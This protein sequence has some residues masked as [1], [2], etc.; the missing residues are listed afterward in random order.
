M[1]NMLMDT[2]ILHQEGFASRQMKLLTRLTEGERVNVYIPEIVK[3]ELIS[4]KADKIL[5]DINDIKIKIDNIRRSTIYDKD[6]DDSLVNISQYFKK[7]SD[8][9]DQ[10]LEEDF[11]NWLE[12]INGDLI[13]FDPYITENVI[14]D[15]F[16]GSG[17]FKRPKNRQD[18]PDSFIHYAILS[19]FED[20][21][22]DRIYVVIN[23]GA[24]KQ[25][26]ETIEG[27]NTAN[28]L[29]ELF[30]LPEFAQAIKE[31][32][33]ESDR[34]QKIISLLDSEPCNLE[35]MN[36]IY[37]DRYDAEEIMLSGQDILN[38]EDVLGM[39]ISSSSLNE[40]QKETLYELE[41]YKTDYLGDEI[42]S[43]GLSFKAYAKLQ[44]ESNI[45]EYV[46]LIDDLKK[47]IE[48]ISQDDD[49]N[50]EFS[51]EV[52]CKFIGNLDLHVFE[53]MKPEELSIHIQY[54]QTGEGPLFALMNIQQ[55]E[56]I[57][58]E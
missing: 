43:V 17:A 19:V 40:L 21:A 46:G 28:S 56:V 44:Y 35:L 33:E 34:I 24:F 20:Y 3:R 26:L 8:Q 39:K 18:F 4:K 57:S 38:A 48:I 16:K 45:V 42:Y 10:L 7:M 11:S 9:I 6:R 50:C 55:A 52:L 51:V 25:R 49:G 29:K 12:K 36:Y 22:L 23:D 27:I 32:D 5:E 14:D 2:N 54:L 13:P 30:S 1:L 37:S 41:F 47:Y 53:K 31:L 15:Y 58:L